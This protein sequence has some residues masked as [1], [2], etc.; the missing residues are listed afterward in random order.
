MVPFCAIRGCRIDSF[1]LPRPCGP[2]LIGSIRPARTGNSSVPDGVLLTLRRRPVLLVTDLFCAGPDFAGA[3]RFCHM[4]RAPRGCLPLVLGS[5]RRGGP[6]LLFRIELCLP[7]FRTH[8]VHRD[9]GH[10]KGVVRS[11]LRRV[12]CPSRRLPGRVAVSSRGG[13]AGNASRVRSEL[14]RRHRVR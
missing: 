8:F 3:Q 12:L 6:L 4:R 9:R 10:I 1:R 5:A 2:V 11:K 13:A 14:P 7:R